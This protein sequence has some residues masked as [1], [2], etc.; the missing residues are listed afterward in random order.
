MRS[1]RRAAAPSARASTRS[2]CTWRTATCCTSSCRRSPIAAPTATAASFEQR[3][4]FPLEVFDAVR[5]AWPRRAP[6]RR[7]PVVHRLG[8]RRMDARRIG[9]TV[10]PADRARLRL[11]RRVERRRL[12]RAEDSAR[13][14]LPGALRARDP[15]GDGRRHDGR[16]ADHDARPGARR[17]SPPATPTW[18]RWRG[19]SCGT[20]AGRGTPRRRSAHGRRRRRSTRARAPRDAAGVFRGAAVGQR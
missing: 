4:R 10:A 14:G 6:A 8:R 20:R 16:G 3:I 13:P 19:R 5:A 12:A 11:D 18:S 7:A 2:S 1:R 17:S 15:A 9:R